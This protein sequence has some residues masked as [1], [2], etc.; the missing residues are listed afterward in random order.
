MIWL[1]DFY[2]VVSSIATLLVIVMLQCC[3]SIRIILIDYECINERFCM[4]GNGVT[5][6]KCYAGYYCYMCNY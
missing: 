6:D 2:I 1:F 3:L 5:M 4:V